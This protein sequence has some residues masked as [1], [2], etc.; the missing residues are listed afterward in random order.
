MYKR[1][2]QELRPPGGHG[3][4]GEVVLNGLQRRVHGQQPPPLVQDGVGPAPCLGQDPIFQA[5][6]GE[7]LPIGPGLVA[8]FPAEAP[9]GLK[10]G[11][12]GHQEELGAAARVATRSV[13]YWAVPGGWMWLHRPSPGEE[14]EKMG[15][16]EDGRPTLASWPRRIYDWP[17]L[18]ARFGPALDSWRMRGLP[19][20][21]VLSL[22]HI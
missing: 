11:L 5:G 9:L 10:G 15:V 18:P 3:I 12:F 4:A 14:E 21:H 8:V 20:E 22:I 16:R 2:V 7:D 6:E 17:E 13:I 1:Q 19:P